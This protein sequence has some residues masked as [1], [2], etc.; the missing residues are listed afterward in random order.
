MKVN[1]E[2]NLPEEQDDYQMT[3]DGPKA[4]MSLSEIANEIFRPARKYGYGDAQLQQLIEDNPGAFEIISKLES[5]FYEI[6]RSNGV[7]LP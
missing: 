3:I 2:F 6:I 4:F 1:L 7:E 5:M